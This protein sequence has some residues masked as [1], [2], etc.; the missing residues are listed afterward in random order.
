MPTFRCPVVGLEFPALAYCCATPLARASGS[1]QTS[2]SQSDSQHHDE[3]ASSNAALSTPDRGSAHTTTTLCRPLLFL[4]RCQAP[5]VWSPSS[6]TL[7]VLTLYSTNGTY[8]RLSQPWSPSVRESGRIARLGLSAG[9][10]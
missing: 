6:P 2:Q 5:F 4:A 10:G 7:P 9:L 8:L 3:P 1:S